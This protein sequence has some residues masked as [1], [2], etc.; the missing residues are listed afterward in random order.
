MSSE[1]INNLTI[2]IVVY[3]EDY[4]LLYKTLDK[5]KNFKIIII[6]NGND[7]LLKN[8]VKKNFKIENYI[9]NKKNNGFSAGYNQVAKLCKSKYLL[10]MNPDCIISEKNI[11]IMFDYISNDKDCFIVCPT[12]YDS[13]MKIMTYSGGNLIE[14][15]NIDETLN[16][17]GNVCVESCLG[18][19]MLLRTD[20]FINIGLFDENFF[21]YFSDYDLC[22][23]IKKINKSIVQLF[24][25]QCI[26]SHGN[27]KI[28]NKFQKLFIRENNYIYDKLYYYYKINPSHEEI[29]LILKKLKSKFFKFLLNIIMFKLQNAFK[30]AGTIYAILRFKSNQSKFSLQ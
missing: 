20:D 2:G 25:A 21:I 4:S 23:R 6:D 11:S 28:K 9:L 3:K 30:D 19:C 27:L 10:L 12:S 13:Q 1:Y 22:R 18:F 26:H 7:L 17:T 14:N 5:I 29:K 24:D 8:E 15:K 16:L